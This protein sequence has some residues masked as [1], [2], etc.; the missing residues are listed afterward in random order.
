MHSPTLPVVA[1]HDYRLS[2]G[3]LVVKEARGLTILVKLDGAWLCDACSGSLGF[4]S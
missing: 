4:L 3:E 2:I 1:M